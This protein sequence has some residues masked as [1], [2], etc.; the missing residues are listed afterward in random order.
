M[1]NHN[2]IFIGGLHRSGTSILH[3]CL[4]KHPLIS[5]FFDTCSPEDEGQHLQSV[6]LPAR[7]YGGPGRFGFD[8]NARLTEESKLVSEEN[9]TKLIKE[10]G[11]HWDLS[12]PYLMEKSPP[13]LI[14]MRF[15]QRMFN[16]S[17]FIIITR[18]PVACAYA[19]KEM[20]KKWSI[21]SLIKHWLTCHQIFDEDKKH[22]NKIFVLKYEDFVLQPKIWLNKICNFLNISIIQNFEDISSAKNEKYYGKWKK[23]SNILVKKYAEWKYEKKVNYFNYSLVDF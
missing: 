7:N 1:K 5:G 17:Y 22:I 11:M 20:Q 21:I 13:N 2:F 16:N 15:L 9:R 23:P 10:W 18:H 14:K 12:K 8:P 19:T 4:R 3:R 6:Y